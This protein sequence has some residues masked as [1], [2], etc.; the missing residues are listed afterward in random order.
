MPPDPVKG[1]AQV[2]GVYLEPT[3]SQSVRVG[4]L[5]KDH[6]ATVT[7]IVDDAYIALGPQRPILSLAF[8]GTAGEEDTIA[9][10][11]DRTNKVGTA[12]ALP[13]T[14]A[15]LLPEGALRAVVESQLPAMESDDYGMLKRLGGD[16]PGAVVIREEGETA[17][18]TASR[19]RRTR[20][21]DG[22]AETGEAG[23]VKFSLAGVQMKFSMALA[24]N[25]LT[26]PAQGESGHVVAKMPS[27]DHPDLPEV[28]Y[29]AMKLAEAAGVEIAEIRLVP[30]RLVEGV[31]PAFLRLGK[32]VLAV[33]RFDR[34]ADKRIHMEDFAQIVGAVGNQKYTKTNLET[35]VNLCSRFTPDPHE[36]VLEMIRRIVVDLMLGNGDNHLKNTSFLYPDGRTPTLSPAYDIVP[37]V[38]YQPKDDL[39]LRFGGKKAFESITLH[40][41]ER[42]ASYVDINPKV[43][44]REIEL[45]IERASDAWPKLTN[46]L[47]WPKA[48]TKT[49]AAR[50][51]RLTMFEDKKNPFT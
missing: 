12:S 44:V 24:G 5:L 34:S 35:V 13:G 37:T 31:N 46:E 38:F 28:E 26:L 20:A 36:A 43:V 22:K 25:R 8:H 3:R 51:P 11:R 32:N 18:S 19:N 21:A 14:F 40:E 47:P 9:R 7:F 16:L 29:G 1:R 17:A 27:K 2:L 49:L 23:L 6:A 45:T 4:S 39:A 30:T 50:W 10:L 42:M 15:N 41:F 33:T 48:V